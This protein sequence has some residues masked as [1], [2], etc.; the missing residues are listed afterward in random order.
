MKKY[1]FGM[2]AIVFAVGPKSRFVDY[3]FAYN[4]PGTMTEAQVELPSNWILTADLGDQT[5]PPICSGDLIKAC[6]IKVPESATEVNGGGTRVLKS[7]A[8]IVASP[9]ASPATTHY[10]S[11]GSSVSAFLNKN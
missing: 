6:R 7:T 2:L 5:I 1:L 8:L 3:F 11:G 10:V 4:G 9:A